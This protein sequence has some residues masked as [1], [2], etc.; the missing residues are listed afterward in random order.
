MTAATLSL[1]LARTIRLIPGYD[2]FV[3]SQDC[4][5]D[6][7]AARLALDFFPECLTHIEGELAGQPFVLQPW[8]EAII[9]NLFGWKTR[10]EKGRTIRRYREALI[11][12]PRKNGK[13]PLAAGIGLYHLFCDPERGQQSFIMASTRE[14]AGFLFRHCRGMVAQQP[15]LDTRCQVF[16]GHATSGQSHSIVRPDSGSFLKIVSGDSNRGQHGKNANLALVDELHELTDRDP[17]D[18]LRTAMASANKPQPLLVY[19]TTS[20]FDREGSLCN[21]IH[22]YATK[23]RDGVITD[24]A[25]LPVIYE[26]S[27]D[28]DWTSPAV[29]ARANPNLR[30]SVSI[31][32]IERECQRAQEL[33][34]YENT[35]KRLHLN[36]RTEQ[37]VRWLQLDKWDAC[38]GTATPQEMAESL[39]G[40]PCWCG[41]DLSATTDLSALAMVFRDGGPGRYQVLCHFWVPAENA[42]KRQRRD[43]V[44]YL[45][46]IEDG[47]ITA[48]P[49]DV[50]DYDCIRADI[51]ELGTR[52]Q[53]E[54]IAADRWN[55]YQ[56]ITQLDGDGFTIFPFGQ[57]YASMSGPAK[58]LEK[59]IIGGQLS[60]GG[61]PVLRWMASNVT[62]EQDAAGNIKPNKKKSSERI[63]GIVALCM[64]LGRASVHDGGSIY[65]TEEL[66]LL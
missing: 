44:P 3:G 38:C 21:E 29:W 66:L 59:V 41:L 39:R 15:A 23:V 55:A 48:T 16:G 31:E 56:L 14:Q 1:E 28:D 34:T 35:F 51:N 10:N 40:E 33:P 30:I 22:D 13:T 60:H 6:E 53:I 65:D 64:G 18:A 47:W 24:A 42:R 11:F 25:F 46:W 52:Y 58:E 2:P 37:D 17:V 49:G 20:D 43:R 7:D 4:W 27:L 12:V 19:T 50:V 45:Q 32:F 63:D 9:A 54:E 62:V 57:G 61:N 36:I 5:F 26:A 8:Q